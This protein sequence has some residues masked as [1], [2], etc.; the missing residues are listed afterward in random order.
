MDS[1][2]KG[3]VDM[4]HK[5]IEAFFS[6]LE[7][8]LAKPETLKSEGVRREW[9]SDLE[10]QTAITGSSRFEIDS[11]QTKNGYPQTYYFRRERFLDGDDWNYRIIHGEMDKNVKVVTNR[12]IAPAFWSRVDVESESGNV[13]AEFLATG[14]SSSCEISI[15]EIAMAYAKS[16]SEWEDGAVEV[17]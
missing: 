10:R 14:G 6:F 13:V 4:E 7:R 17:G 15:S 11:S 3:G 2:V 8:N 1:K 12:S 16:F 9:E 5:N